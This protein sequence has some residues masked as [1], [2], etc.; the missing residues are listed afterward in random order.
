[1]HDYFRRE[2][3]T[4]MN[5]IPTVQG[6]LKAII[7]NIDYILRGYEDVVEK[8]SKLGANIEIIE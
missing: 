8:L 4:V 1:V 7:D 5:T 3:V 2:E 6:I